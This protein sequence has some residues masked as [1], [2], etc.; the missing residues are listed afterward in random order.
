MSTY[1]DVSDDDTLPVGV[2]KVF[3]LRIA[4]KNHW[5]STFRSWGRREDAAYTRKPFR[6]TLRKHRRDDLR[7]LQ[8][9]SLDGLGGI[10]NSSSPKG[11]P[12]G[13]P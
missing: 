5:S 8:D 6:L 2:Q 3:S 4:P 9:I 7:V 1:S 11:S 13:S 10:I 12:K